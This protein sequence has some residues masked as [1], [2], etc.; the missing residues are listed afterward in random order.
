MQKDESVAV[1]MHTCP[2][3]FKHGKWLSRPS[4][5]VAQTTTRAYSNH[6]IN[7]HSQTSFTPAGTCDCRPRHYTFVYTCV[8]KCESMVI[9]VIIK[10]IVD[11]LNH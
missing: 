6:H 7:N 11:S 4:A 9:N 10:V 1:S 3:A 8:C 5:A 2:P